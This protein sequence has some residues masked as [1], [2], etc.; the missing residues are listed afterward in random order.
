MLGGVPDAALYRDLVDCA[1]VG[2]FTLDASGKLTFANR[3]LAELVGVGSA[4]QLT[5]REFPL[6]AA[7]A[8]SRQRL[9]ERLERRQSFTGLEC[10]IAAPE[11]RTRIVKIGAERAE[12]A[13][14][15]TVVDVSDD[16]RAE[17]ELRASEELSRRI[18]DAM[19]GGVVEY[20]ADFK[21]VRITAEAARFFGAPPEELI[22]V[23]V[24]ELESVTIWEDGST[25]RAEDYPVT[26][27][28]RTRR[29]QL[30]VTIGFTRRDGV[31]AW[32]MYT[33]V[34]VS[35]DPDGP[36]GAIVTFLDITARKRTEQALLESEE[37]YRELVQRSPDPM[38]VQSGGRMLFV[39]AAGAR[40]VQKS[41]EALIGSMAMDL[42]HPDSRELFDDRVREVFQSGSGCPIFEAKL[43]RADGSSVDVEVAAVPLRYH[44]QP[45]VQVV[46][47]DITARKLAEEE[48]RR[49]EAQVRYAQKL[50]SLGVLAGGIA[51]DFNNLLAVV[52]GNAAM[53]V[54]NMPSDA[55]AR[56]D[57][58]RIEAAAE[59]AA[60]LTK[61]MLAYAGK[62]KFVVEPLD[63]ARLVSEMADLLK[64]ALPKRVRLETTC[65][66]GLP[67]ILA[68]AAQVQQVVMNL[69]T[70]AAD[71]IGD[72]PGVVS[73]EIARYELDGS[74]SDL[75]YVADDFMA[76]EFVC[77]EVRDTG[78]G[79]DTATLAKIFD[80]F[81][82]TKM[83]G[84]G[85]G[86]AA[87]LGIVRGHH[88]AISVTSAP[89]AGCMFRVFFPAATQHVHREPTSALRRAHALSGKTVLVIDD[90]PGIRHIT[91]AN[92]EAVGFA[93]LLAEHG[94]QGLHMFREHVERI[95]AVLLDLTMPDMSGAD[96][97]KEL[98]TLKPWVRV[99][100]SSGYSEE[101]AQELLE[102]SR[103]CS[104]LQKPYR[105]AA[106]VDRLQRMLTS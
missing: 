33:A 24:W 51:H 22:G 86:L 25:C 40:L 85:L 81:F 44:G 5:G 14:R 77:L 74:R 76:G 64:T 10:T 94:Q 53:A 56:R 59:R 23:S 3:A 63:L 11:G 37:R 46:A 36:G 78:H 82:T 50:E 31:T 35:E 65:Q 45:A 17:E 84:R 21:L 60:E 104:F 2:L 29:R 72:A 9:A 41:P 7:D 87:T 99:I 75:S 88:G 19:P 38:A 100:L 6:L 26:K 92:L 91:R 102:I 54:L 28:L 4:D 57:V 30:P 69:I 42:V 58:E 18:I 67:S 16:R 32:A 95:D 83:A 68:D 55:A 71:A 13:W 15:G 52:M 73:I 93:V 97:L 27:C 89:G 101:E 80:P 98:I 1:G 79:M 103:C 20:A 48:L 39:N 90:E 49:L 34:P 61:Q 96:V 70:N 47:R 66:P 105:P 106:L 43:L 12:H 62:G 8:S